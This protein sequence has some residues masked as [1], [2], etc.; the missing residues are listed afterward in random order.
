MKGKR[1]YIQNLSKPVKPA[2]RFM[3]KM[4]KSTCKCANGGVTAIFAPFPFITGAAAL[5]GAIII[6]PVISLCS[7]GE[8]LYFSSGTVFNFKLIEDVAFSS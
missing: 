6:S 3:G 2:S 1:T 4:W 5:G 8:K 7:K